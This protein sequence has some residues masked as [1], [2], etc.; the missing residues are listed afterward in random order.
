MEMW[1]WVIVILAV[2]LIWGGIS[3]AWRAFSR[4]PRVRS[5][6]MKK[7]D[8]IYFEGDITREE[9]LRRKAELERKERKK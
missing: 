7:L 4:P 1:G 2:A 3:F 9:Y 8:E 5:P 6:A